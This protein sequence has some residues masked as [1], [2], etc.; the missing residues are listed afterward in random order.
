MPL[1][2]F[3][4]WEKDNNLIYVPLINFAIRQSLTGMVKP[5]FPAFLELN[6]VQEIEELRVGCVN[7]TYRA[8]GQPC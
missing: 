1:V 8:T 5:S 2:I 7:C 6:S 4:I 3:V